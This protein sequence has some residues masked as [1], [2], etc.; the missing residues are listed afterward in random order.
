MENYKHLRTSGVLT[1]GGKILENKYISQ[2]Q[3]Q[4]RLKIYPKIKNK[5]A[6][7]VRFIGSVKKERRLDLYLIPICLHFKR[8][9]H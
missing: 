3:E 2:D 8:V 4:K 5:K 6:S 7:W 1:F 9:N